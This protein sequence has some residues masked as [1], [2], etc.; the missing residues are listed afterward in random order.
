M[1]AST[2]PGANTGPNRAIGGNR[3]KHAV[4]GGNPEKRLE[5][6]APSP[7]LSRRLDGIKSS[8]E[9]IGELSDAEGLEP[10]LGVGAAF[11]GWIELQVLLQH[12]SRFGAIPALFVSQ[13]QMI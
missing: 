9:G 2:L 11:R 6:I 12:P 10:A 7:R 8:W 13:R 4:V 1:P 3:G 5:G